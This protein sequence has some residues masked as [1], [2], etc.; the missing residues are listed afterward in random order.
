MPLVST[1]FSHLKSEVSPSSTSFVISDPYQGARREPSFSPLTCSFFS[2]PIPLLSVEKM[3]HAPLVCPQFPPMPPLLF[4]CPLASPPSC[5]PLCSFLQLSSNFPLDTRKV[6]FFFTLVFSPPPLLSVF[7]FFFSE[8]LGMSPIWNDQ[9]NPPTQLT[10]TPQRSRCFPPNFLS[11]SLPPPFEN[12]PTKTSHLAGLYAL[13]DYQTEP[14][15]SQTPPP[16]PLFSTAPNRIFRL[17]HPQSPFFSSHK[18]PFVPAP[19]SSSFQV[20]TGVCFGDTSP[21]DC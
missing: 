5:V 21:P 13:P 6:F 7:P 14:F 12:D 11:P 1:S 16:P 3:S 4:L 8:S 18:P 9:I 17:Q 15:S 2:F 20:F 19:S 10:D